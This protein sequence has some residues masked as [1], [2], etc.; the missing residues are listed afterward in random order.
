MYSISI[1][2]DSKQKFPFNLKEKEKI[3]KEKDTTYKGQHNAPYL[4]DLW[5]A[6]AW[7]MGKIC[8]ESIP[9]LGLNTFSLQN[10]ASTTNMIPSTAEK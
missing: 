5:L 7:D 9:I 1:K 3:T 6:L 2:N 10:P 8:R 4:P